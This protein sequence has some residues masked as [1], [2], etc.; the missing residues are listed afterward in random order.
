MDAFNY[1]YECSRIHTSS[2]R[3]IISLIPKKSRDS[4]FLKNWRPIILLCCDYKILAKIIAHCI[5]STLSELINECQTGFIAQRNIATNIQIAA[6]IADHVNRRNINAVMLQL[7]FLKAFGRVEYASLFAA[8][9]YFGFGSNIIKW[10]KILFTDIELCTSNNGFA[11]EYFTPSRGLFQGNPVSSMGFLLIV[12]LLSINLRN[13]PHLQGITIKN[14]NFL[15]AMFADDVTIFLKNTPRNGQELLKE[16]EEFEILSGLKVNYDKS[17]VYRMGSANKANARQY[18]LNKVKWSDKPPNILGVYISP[19]WQDSLNAKLEGTLENIQNM[20]EIWSKRNLSL[21]G[22]IVNV[23]TLAYP[24]LL[25][26]LTNIP[27]LEKAYIKKYNRIISEFIW[28]KKKSKIPQHIMHGLK[29]NGG[30]GLINLESKDKVAKIQWVCKI[31][32]N[33][34]IAALAEDALGLQAGNLIWK[35]NIEQDD[36]DHICNNRNFWYFVLKASSPINC[37]T[38]ISADQIKHQVLWYNSNICINNLPFVYTNWLQAGIRKISDLVDDAGNMLSLNQ[39]SNRF[40]SRL[41]FTEYYG[42]I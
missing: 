39:L 17:T 38:P 16:I 41:P 2:R 13:N 3:G 32:S 14:I 5:K 35:A 4:R 33:P 30:L 42:L 11:S 27:S 24:T 10:L 21:L 34:M 22:K 8:M 18:V 28:D 29:Q 23:N 19:K 20:M 9:Q 40:D 7:D 12:E 6:D 37:Q 25:Y 31:E 36:I 1:A 26:K 15:L